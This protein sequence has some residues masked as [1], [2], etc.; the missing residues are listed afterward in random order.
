MHTRTIVSTGVTHTLPSPILP[1]R[2]DRLVDL[3]VVAAGFG[4]R[5]AEDVQGLQRFADVVQRAFRAAP[6]HLAADQ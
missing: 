6:I 3:V 2:A 5:H 4:H 1:R